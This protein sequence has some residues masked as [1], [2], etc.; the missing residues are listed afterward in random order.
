M[1][2]WCVD[3]I[4]CDDDY[5]FSQENF[6]PLGVLLRDGLFHFICFLVSL[7]IIGGFNSNICLFVWSLS[8]IRSRMVRSIY[9]SHVEIYFWR[10]HGS[11]L[12]NIGEF[13][14]VYIDSSFHYNSEGFR[15]LSLFWLPSALKVE[16]FN[17]FMER[18]HCRCRMEEIILVEMG[19]IFFFAGIFQSKFPE[20]VA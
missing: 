10:F 19:E 1:I 12:G 20:S 8:T 9:S 5:Y 14:H 15:D 6:F 3:T 13:S 16:V 11:R 4:I 2:F 18:C 17:N 7:S